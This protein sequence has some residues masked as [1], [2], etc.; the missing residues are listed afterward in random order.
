MRIGDP[1]ACGAL[2]GN[3]ILGRILRFEGDLFDGVQ[4]LVVL[5]TPHGSEVRA[6]RVW[7]R[8]RLSQDEYALLS[9]YEA[10]A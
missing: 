3:A 2:G 6:G 5:R 1:V 9:K 10:Q 7:I 4:P 8:T